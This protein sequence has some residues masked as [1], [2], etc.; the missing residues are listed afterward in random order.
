MVI[1]R[2][3]NGEVQQNF[4]DDG[5]DAKLVVPLTHERWPGGVRPEAVLPEIPA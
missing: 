4:G 1:E 2:Q 5:F 3:L